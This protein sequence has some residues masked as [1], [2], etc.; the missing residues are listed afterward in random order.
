MMSRRTRLLLFGALL[1]PAVVGVSVAFLWR[2]RSGERPD[3]GQSTWIDVSPFGHVVF[4]V[5]IACAVGFTLS[6]IVDLRHRR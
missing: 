3:W 6:L 1:A 5:G 4:W 2:E